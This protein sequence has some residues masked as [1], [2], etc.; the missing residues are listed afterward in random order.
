LGAGADIHLGKHVMISPEFQLWSSELR[1]D[2][3][4]LNLGAALNFRLKIFFVGG[5]VNIPIIHTSTKT[6]VFG[7]ISAK[8]NVGLR[9]NRIKLTAYLLTPFEDFF[10]CIQVGANIG[11][12]FYLKSP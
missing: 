12:V 3:L 1:L 7:L 2:I 5:G 11:I 4:Q 6:D 10:E 9:I 8:I